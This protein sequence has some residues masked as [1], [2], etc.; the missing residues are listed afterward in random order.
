[1]LMIRILASV[2]ATTLLILSFLNFPSSTIAKP[3]LLALRV[4]PMFYL[5]NS[6]LRQATLKACDEGTP[7]ERAAHMQ[8]NSCLY[9][10]DAGTMPQYAKVANASP[11]ATIRKEHRMRAADAK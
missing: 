9:A 7:E 1:M 11:G 8:L 10:V 6:K 2:S 5:Q 3:A 4:D